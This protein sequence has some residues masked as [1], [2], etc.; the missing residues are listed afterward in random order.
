MRRW[1]YGQA[2]N[3]ELRGLKITK[4]GTKETY[5]PIAVEERVFDESK[6]YLYPIPQSEI[7]KG[8]LEQNV[9]W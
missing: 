2:F 5:E 7:D 1:Q 6:M 8:H 3:Q 9:N 4:D